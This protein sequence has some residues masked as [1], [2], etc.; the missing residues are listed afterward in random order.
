MRF[1]LDPSKKYSKILEEI[2]KEKNFDTE[3]N[4]LLL[5]ILNHINDVYSDYKSIKVNVLERDAILGNYLETIQDDINKIDVIKEN[6]F[7]INKEDLGKTGVKPI[8]KEK[9]EKQKRIIDEKNKTILTQL[10]PIELYNSIAEI[11]PK[12]F[13]VK[14]EYLFKDILQNMLAKG[15][16]INT[17]EIMRDF[18]GFS[19][20]TRYSENFLYINN[21]IYQNL[22]ILLG[23]DFMFQWE[24]Q[25]SNLPDYVQEMKLSLLKQFGEE[26]TNEILDAFYGA[27]YTYPSENPRGK[28]KAQVE[29]NKRIL[30]TMEDS[31]KF[32]SYIQRQKN[33]LNKNLSSIDLMLNNDEALVDGFNEQNAKLDKNKQITSIVIFKNILESERIKTIDKFDFFTMLQKPNHFIEYKSELKRQIKTFDENKTTKES[34]IELETVILNALY[35]KIEKEEVSVRLMEYLK[36]LRYFKFIKVSEE[37]SIKDIKELQKLIEKTEKLLVTKLCKLG[38]LQMFSFDIDINYNIISRILD[39]RLLDLEELLVEL[40]YKPMTIGLRIYDKNTIE[41]EEIINIKKTPD[42]AVKLRRKLKLFR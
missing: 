23:A 15:A 5:L 31:E 2:L 3:I 24:H 32:L 7:T 25:R 27:I 13:Y 11:Q 12:Y 9:K 10:S 6:L 33:V 16:S 18:K 8:I 39:T 20:H 19:W 30:K 4:N 1:F 29:K 38:S 40:D 28:I 14:E 37:K 36:I 42:L 35:S 17:T 22:I 26:H 41:K 34:I 21:L